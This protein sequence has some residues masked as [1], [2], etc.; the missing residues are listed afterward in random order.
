MESVIRAEKERDETKQEARAAQLVATSAGDAKARVEV[1]MSKALNSLAAEEE[2]GLRSEGEIACLEAELARVEAK[3]A[4][5]FL[6]LEASKGEVSSLQ[7]RAYKD[8]EDMLK[9]YQGSLE[10]IFSYGYGFYTFKNN[11]NGDRPEIPDCMPDSTNPLAQEFFVN[12]RC[13]PTPTAV[14][15]KDEEVDQGRTVEDSEGGVVA[16]E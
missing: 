13:P 10:L 14:E 2:G 11:I 9:D 3:R 6:A 7:A 15:A 5:L 1:N 4:L 8:R 12:T 16:K